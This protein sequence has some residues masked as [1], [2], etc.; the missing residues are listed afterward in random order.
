VAAEELVESGV[1]AGG[2]KG[3]QQLAI[4][5]RRRSVLAGS[6]AQAAQH[7]AE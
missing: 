2:Y 7:L 4:R 3:L 5:L 6:T 1:V